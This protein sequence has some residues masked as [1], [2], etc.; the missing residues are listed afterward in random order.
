VR[1]ESRDGRLLAFSSGDQ[2]TGM[3]KTLIRAD[4]IAMLAA[5]RTS[6]AAGDEVDVRVMSNNQVMLEG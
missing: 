1:L 6:F 5:E 2:M 4:G 3:L